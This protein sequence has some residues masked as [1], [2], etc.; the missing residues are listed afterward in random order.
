MTTPDSNVVK[1]R[2]RRLAADYDSAMSFLDRVR[3][4][5][6]EHLDLKPGE[7]VLD[8]GCG[9]GISFER[10][11]RDVG[12]QG[13]IIGL[14]LNCE[15][16]EFAP[17]PRCEPI[18]SLTIQD[19]VTQF[20]TTRRKVHRKVRATRMASL[21]R[22]GQLEMTKPHLVGSHR[23]SKV[24]HRRCRIS[25]LRYGGRNERTTTVVPEGRLA[26]R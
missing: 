24:Y 11:H 23:H 26:C 21:W 8:L 4:A 20:G 9:T 2:Y 1:D 10:L 16:V 18:N 15:M 12:P 7:S 25:H 3:E 13:R 5:S 6:F 14:K 17:L 22:G 19:K